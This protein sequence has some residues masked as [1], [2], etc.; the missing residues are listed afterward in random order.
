MTSLLGGCRGEGSRP[1]SRLLPSP[2]NIF[3]EP[4]LRPR[5][6]SGKQ[7]AGINYRRLPLHFIIKELVIMGK[8]KARRLKQTVN[9]GW[10][11]NLHSY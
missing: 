1:R 9:F 2:L 6:T 3:K 8:D 10:K 5:G 11:L 7:S 4:S